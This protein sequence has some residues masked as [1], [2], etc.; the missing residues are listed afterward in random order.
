MIK[1]TAAIS[2]TRGLNDKSTAESF[3]NL[4]NPYATNGTAM[5]DHSA[6]QLKGNIPS[7]ICMAWAFETVS[8]KQHAVSTR[9]IT[10]SFRDGV[11]NIPLFCMGFTF[12][13][14]PPPP[15]A[16]GRIH[17]VPAEWDIFL[18]RAG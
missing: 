12:D 9:S 13:I 14:W 2:P 3:L 15:E 5:I 6:A 8:S 18:V 10:G 11:L 17:I 1:T 16:S 4:Y 7:E